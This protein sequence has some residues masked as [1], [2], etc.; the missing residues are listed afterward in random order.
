MNGNL[1]AKGGLQLIQGGRKFY[2]IPAQESVTKDDESFSYGAHGQADPAEFSNY[3]NS[4]IIGN[5]ATFITP[6]GRRRIIYCDHIASGK[7]VEFI[8]DFLR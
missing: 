3:I 4:N 7:S 2:E 6:F 5:N 8:E 1:D